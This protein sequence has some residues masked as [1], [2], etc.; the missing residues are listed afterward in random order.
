MATIGNG[1]K[2]IF[3]AGVGAMAL[4]GE[5]ASELVDKMIARGELSVEQGKEINQELAH[6]AEETFAKVRTDALEQAMAAMSPEER[7]AFAAKAVEIA[8]KDAPKADGAQDAPAEGA[9][10]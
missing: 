10:G 2:D 8:A 1:L 3:L 5:K 4:T 7:A 6:K 9:E